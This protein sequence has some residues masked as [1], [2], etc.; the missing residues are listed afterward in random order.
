MEDGIDAQKESDLR[1][2]SLWVLFLERRDSMRTRGMEKVKG[3]RGEW[4]SELENL[5]RD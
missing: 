4:V 5:E 3:Q 1:V 2:R